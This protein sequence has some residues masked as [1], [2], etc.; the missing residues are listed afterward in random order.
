MFT[1]Y[2]RRNTLIVFSCHPAA[3]D[4][5][6]QHIAEQLTEEWPEG[7]DPNTPLCVN[8]TGQADVQY[9]AQH[10]VIN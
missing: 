1:A 3:L 4:A 6:A 10:V 2:G 5:A 8:F 9:F 7:M